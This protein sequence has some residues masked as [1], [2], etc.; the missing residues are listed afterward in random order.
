[1]IPLNINNGIPLINQVSLIP[2]RKRNLVLLPQ[3]H[4][5]L[6]SFL[7]KQTSAKIQTL[8]LLQREIL[9]VLQRATL[10]PICGMMTI[11]H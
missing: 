8:P 11:F 10:I 5:V 4:A 1:V 2:S 3:S 9:P 7:Q 6:P